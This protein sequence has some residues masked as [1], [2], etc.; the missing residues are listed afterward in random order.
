MSSQARVSS[1]TRSITEY[2]WPA[3]SVRSIGSPPASL[4]NWI[5]TNAPRRL[6]RAMAFEVKQRCSAAASEYRRR[7]FPLR[8]GSPS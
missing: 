6:R 8:S 1:P 2:T 5:A 4:R 3:R 7:R